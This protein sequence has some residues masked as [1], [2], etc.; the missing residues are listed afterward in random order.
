MQ[1]KNEVDKGLSEFPKNLPS[2]YFYD[3]KG[4]ALFVKIM[5][6]PEYYL[7]RAELEIFKNQSAK[8]IENLELDKNQ[9]FELIE[10]GAG[11]GTKTKQLLKELLKNNYKFDYFPIDFSQNALDKLDKNL[12]EDLPE[13]SVKKKQGD[14]FEVLASFR[15]TTHPKVV[16][17]LGSNLGN[18]TDQLAAEFIYKLGVNLKKNDI[19]FLG[20]DLIKSTDIVLPAYSDD[21]GVTKAF[22]IN[23]LSRI[24]NELGGNFKIDTFTH[25]AKYTEEEGIA[26]SYLVS[27]V[28]QTVSLNGSGKIYH[29]AQGEKIHT[30]ISR[31]Y[32]DEIISNIIKNTDF[33]IINKLIDSKAYFADYIL[34]RD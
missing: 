26:K 30:E 16:L 22:N 6:L 7:T 1:F 5:N 24:N 2:K 20:L 25:L 14:Y 27:T 33:K 3:K 17:F 19:L 23:L 12:R 34:K 21:K 18:M 10:L 31:K 11:D 9:Y 13:I 8:I 28:E 32:N 4:D 29:F 15:E